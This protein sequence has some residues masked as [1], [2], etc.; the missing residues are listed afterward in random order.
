MS[1]KTPVNKNNCKIKR[2]G[3]FVP[4]CPKQSAPLIEVNMAVIPLTQKRKVID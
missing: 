2:L 3:G 1:Q 4:K